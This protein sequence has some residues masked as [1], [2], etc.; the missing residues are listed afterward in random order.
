LNVPFFHSNDDYDEMIFYHAGQFFSRDYIY[1]GMV[2][3]HPSGI[4]HGPHPKALQNADQMRGRLTNEVAVMIDTRNA[5]DISQQAK[6]IEWP[7][8]VNSWK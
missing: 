8:Y 4:P 5:L 7:D 1:P 6:N 3:L 2:T